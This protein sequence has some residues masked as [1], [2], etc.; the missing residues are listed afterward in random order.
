[1][2]FVICPEQPNTVEVKLVERGEDV[3]VVASNKTACHTIL[4]LNANGTV[5]LEKGVIDR[6][7]FCLD[8]NGSV[9]TD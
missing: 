9:M 4:T 7:G 3:A 1:M 5:R 6:L 8:A 2:K